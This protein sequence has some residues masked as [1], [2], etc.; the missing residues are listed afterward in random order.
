MVILGLLVLLAGVVVIL[1]AVF[2]HEGTASLLG[3]D[4]DALTIFLLGVAAGLAILFGYAILK[5]GAK[6]EITRRREN[7]RLNELSEKLERVEAER[8]AEGKV[9]EPH[10]D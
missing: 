8:R 10:R 2:S 5:F 1:V 4:L 6:R 9:D 3:R 7:R